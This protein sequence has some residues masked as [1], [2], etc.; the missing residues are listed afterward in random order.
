MQ[1]RLVNTAAEKA[2][3]DALIVPLVEGQT[4]VPPEAQTLDK[5]LK[6]AIAQLLKDREFRGKFMELVPVHN[7]DNA[8]SKWTVLVGVGKL[9]Q[10]DMVRLR[11][12]LQA[13]GRV[14]RKRGHRQVAVLLPKAVAGR[15]SA[16]DLARA[17]AEGIGLSNF[18]VGSL[19]TRHDHAV[20][21]IESLNIIGLD[22]DKRASQALKDAVALSDATNRI[23]D[24]VNAP[25]NA[26][27][28]AMFA[29]KVKDAVKGTG[30]DLKVL[31]V[32]DMRRL[33]M[34]ALLAVA[35]GSD[36]P[37]KM[38]VLRYSGGSKR[39][40]TLGLVGKGIT[41]DSGG[42]SIKPAQHMEMM[43]SDMGGGAAVVGAMLAIAELKPKVNVI[44]VVP[45]TENMPS[46]KAIKPGDVVTGSGGKTI[47][48]INTDA[49]GRLILS[50]GITYA[51]REGAT[52]IVD[53][54]TLTG[55]ITRTLGPLAIGAF[56]ND[57][58]LMELVRRAGE[59]S[60]E[61]LWEL[62]TWADYDGL[63]ESEI[64]DIRNST[65]QWAG[66]TTA[67]L[68][69][70]EFVEGRPWVHLDIAGS[71]WQDAPELKTVPKG[72][73]GSGVRLMAHLAG[74]LAER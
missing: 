60:G 1:A 44:G 52:H 8:A 15:A 24:W 47:E 4:K 46:G 29:D 19:K 12:A 67:A 64:A 7:L 42:I 71:A 9:D 68:F 30:L 66:A 27:T 31:D 72:P 48:I 14:L 35:R 22:G 45:T 50:D 20:T 23:R 43:K 40:P 26:F 2:E 51:I 54:A 61:R 49:E 38:I 58:A 28:P 59:L 5:Q 41:F 55:S 62:P 70:R 57:P 39:G 34:G 25:A 21:Q 56:G 73:T 3:A 17:A 63:I 11:N 65:V 32:D 37:A 13:A 74:L 33:K 10:L 53:I 6:G 69:L 16:A 18:D 36:E